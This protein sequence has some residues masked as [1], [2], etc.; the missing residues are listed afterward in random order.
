MTFDELVQN[1]NAKPVVA[2]FYG[3]AC[4]PCEQ[5]KPV[6][7]AVAKTCKVELQEF[8]SANELPAIRR[9]GVRTVP[10]VFVVSHGEARLAFT[11]A[12]DAE[13]IRDRLNTLG[14]ASPAIGELDANGYA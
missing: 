2:L 7:R 11:G 10:A 5:L 12:M 6:L 9:L 3:A 4:A 8:N 1:S 14:V 13:T